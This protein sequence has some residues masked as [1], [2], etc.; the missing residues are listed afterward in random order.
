MISSYKQST[1]KI[2]SYI[3]SISVT[4]IRPRP[5]PRADVKNKSL[6]KA[7]NAFLQTCHLPDR[8]LNIEG[9]LNHQCTLMDGSI[10]HSDLIC[11]ISLY[12]LLWF[13]L[14]STH[15]INNNLFHKKNIFCCCRFLTLSLKKS[16]KWIFRENF[17]N[18]VLGK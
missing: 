13:L 18:L 2:S 5:V 10:D 15:C 11:D 17:L 3:I 7:F 9:I 1:G 4:L 8:N 14:I 16:V 12:K 6:M